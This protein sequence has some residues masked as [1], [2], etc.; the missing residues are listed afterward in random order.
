MQ[1]LTILGMALAGLALQ[2]ADAAGSD[3]PAVVTILEGS[4]IIFRG[5]SKLGASEGV[6]VQPNDLVETAKGTFLRLEFADGIRL[7]LGPGTRAQVNHPTE[8]SP[9]NPG[10]YVLSGW[11]KLAVDE[12]KR[13]R[14]SGFSTPVFDATD[15]GGTVLARV[16]AHGGALFVERGRARLANRHGHAFAVTELKTDDFVSIGKDG[17]AVLDTRPSSEFVEQMPRSFRDTIPSRLAGY[18]EKEVAPKALGEFSYAE[19][20]PWINAEQVV[21][22]QFVHTWRSKA[23]DPAFR[24]ELT[25]KLSLHPEWG[26]VLFPEL[27][28]PKP[29]ADNALVGPPWPVPERGTPPH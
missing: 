13:S 10:L 9:D 25:G 14:K 6:R 22:R 12:A 26:P 15:L 1:R 3:S 27:Y 23:D 11:I 20:E 4:A 29:A 8:V 7:D 16:D 24:L 5:T 21:R 2:A 19:V 18:S 28:A 17:R